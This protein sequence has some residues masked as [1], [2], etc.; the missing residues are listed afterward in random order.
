MI[1]IQGL[2]ISLFVATIAGWFI[3]NSSWR[4]VLVG[5]GYFDKIH[6][7]RGLQGDA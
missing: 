1:L 5:I 6:M 4:A 2:L 3:N 7:W